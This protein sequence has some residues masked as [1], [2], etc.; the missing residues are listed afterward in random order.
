MIAIRA[1]SEISLSF[2]NLAD[3][4]TENLVHKGETETPRS[5]LLIENKFDIGLLEGSLII[6]PPIH[7]SMLLLLDFDWR[8]LRG[9][10]MSEL[11]REDTYGIAVGRHISETESNETWFMEE[12]IFD[13]VIRYFCIEIEMDKRGT[14]R[15]KFFIFEDKLEGQFP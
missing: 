11:V 8:L 15:G 12:P 2:H 1:K 4:E 10:K 5:L 3:I 6:I 7:R 9:K 14:E 13:L